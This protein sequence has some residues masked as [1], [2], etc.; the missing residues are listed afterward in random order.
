MPV[1]QGRSRGLPAGLPGPVW[2]V[3]LAFVGLELAV[4]ARYGFHRDELYFIACARHL[5][6]GYV[7]QPPLTP[8]LVRLS[9]LV[10]DSPTVLRVLPAVAGAGVVVVSALLARDLGGSRFA[11]GL[12][13]LA[14]ATMPVLLAASHLAGT[15]PYDLL[16]WS[17]VVLLVARAVVRHSGPG[18]LLAG[19]AAGLGLLNKHTIAAFLVPGLVLALLVSPQRRVLSTR[20][21]WLAGLLAVGIAMPTLVWQAR[22]GWPELTMVHALH[23]AHSSASDTVKFLPAQLLYAGPVA[24][25]LW[26]GGLVCLFRDPTL[27]PY[28]FLA[29]WYV[30]LLVAMQVVVPGR[31]Y[32][33]AAM[34]LPLFAAGARWV[35]R[36]E[37]RGLRLPSRAWPWLVGVVGCLLVLLALPVLPERFWH[38]L[39]PKD[40]N[41]DMGE[42]IGWPRMVGQVA[43]VYDG[44]PAS[45]RR[46]TVVFTSNY[47]EA[48]AIDRFGSSVGLPQA[49]S[50]HNAFWG[51]GPPPGSPGTVLLVGDDTASWRGWCATMTAEGQ[52]SNGVGVQDDEL[53]APLTLCSGVRGTWAQIWPTLRHED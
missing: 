40:I 6:W 38:S 7:D 18:W 19:A 44:L 35:E 26:I 34:Y 36:R 29:W 9:L 5:A 22:N 33:L 41:Y 16:A 46:E 25:P 39:P 32:Y 51:W 52:L 11:I 37:R 53:G 17:L 10:G 12:C 28:R 21:P 4:S 1:Q 45:V 3:A 47:G 48:G 15:T 2:A 43:A 8:A 50:G 31:P 14:T 23:T 42:E 20:W 49:Y 24:A 27:Q 13:A 30:V